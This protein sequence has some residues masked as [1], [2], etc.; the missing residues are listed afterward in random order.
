MH[1]A[2]PIRFSLVALTVATSLAAACSR[3]P[4]VSAPQPLA[5]VGD[6]VAGE[7][8]AAELRAMRDTWSSTRSGRDYRFTT[9]YTCFCVGGGEDAVVTVRG[10]RVV[11]VAKRDGQALPA[12]Q[13]YTI[14]ELYVR[15]IAEAEQDGHVEVTYHRSGYPA[16]L[17]VGTLANDAGVGYEVR[18]VVLK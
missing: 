14:E 3:E 9:R 5:A 15:A 11:S 17:V 8:R 18:E 13:Y 7:G 16:R 2:R 1:L 6:T 12:A 4:A 10:D